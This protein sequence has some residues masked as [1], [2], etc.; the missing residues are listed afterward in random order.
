MSMGRISS[1]FMLLL[2]L[3]CITL[4]RSAAAAST[5]GLRILDTSLAVSFADDRVLHVIGSFD[6]GQMVDARVQIRDDVFSVVDA[7]LVDEEDDSIMY[8]LLDRPHGAGIGDRV[9]L[10]GAAASAAATRAASDD[11]EGE[12]VVDAEGRPR[13]WEVVNY[14]DR[15][16]FNVAGIAD[17]ILREG[18]RIEVAGEEYVIRFSY[19]VPSTSHTY[20]RVD[21]DH[22]AR[23]EDTVTLV[24]PAP[25]QP[26]PYVPQAMRP[27]E[28]ADKPAN[29]PYVSQLGEAQA[30]MREFRDHL[31]FLPDASVS[32]VK[33]ETAAR[34]KPG[35]IFVTEPWCGASTY[36]K[37]TVSNSDALLDLWPRFVA[38]HASGEHGHSWQAPGENETYSPRVYVTSAAGAVLPVFGPDSQ[39]PRYFADAEA[40]LS[41]LKDAEDTLAGGAPWNS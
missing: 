38:A 13:T 40:L 16:F 24:A 41:A 39:F 31:A 12:C 35:L 3:L 27:S 22:R 5:P 17:K 32:A 26:V 14:A 23:V 8:L 2:A 37:Q 25:K 30:R 15:N 7:R 36:L 18:A 29:Q 1:S 33:S 21:R 19:V 9:V 28:R 20:V 4:L 10:L 11:D 34:R 6:V